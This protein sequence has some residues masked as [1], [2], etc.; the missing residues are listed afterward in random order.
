VDGF[1]FASTDVGSIIVW[2]SGQRATI[3]NFVD[4]TCVEVAQF[5]EVPQGKFYVFEQLYTAQLQSGWGH[6]GDR[7]NEKQVRA[8][9]I[10]AGSK[11]NIVP[12]IRVEIETNRNT[13]DA[14]EVLEVDETLTNFSEDNLIPTMILATYFRDRVTITDEYRPVW[15]AA[16]TWEVGLVKSRSLTRTL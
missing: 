13:T 6:F 12:S 3:T 14:N 11:S 16:R 7:Y 10:E 1:F 8:Y 2:D 9:L 5:Q 15:L 4:T